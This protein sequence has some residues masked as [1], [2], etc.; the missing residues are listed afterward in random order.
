MEK[1]GMDFF[2]KKMEQKLSE[3]GALI[4]NATKLSAEAKTLSN[5]SYKELVKAQIEIADLYEFFGETF[6]QTSSVADDSSGNIEN[7]ELLEKKE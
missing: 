4:A 2:E 6:S 1:S 3:V 5:D 7:I